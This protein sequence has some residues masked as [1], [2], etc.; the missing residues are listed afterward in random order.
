MTRSPSAVRTAFV[1]SGIGA[2]LC[3]RLVKYWKTTSLSS[4]TSTIRLWPESVISVS[5]LGSRLAQ[6]AKFTGFVLLGSPLPYCQTMWPP[7]VISMTR[8]LF[9][10]AMRMWPLGSSSAL[11]GL[12]SAPGPDVGPYDQTIDLLKRPTS[13]TRLL[14]WSTIMMLRLGSW[15]ANTGTFSSLGPEPA[16]P[17]CPYCQ[18]ILPSSFTTITRLSGQA[19][20]EST[21]DDPFGT[22]VPAS[23]VR[24]SE[25]R[26]ASL[27]PMMA[28]GPG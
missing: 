28:P 15:M 24:P 21:G 17:A 4:V 14:A 1:G 26:S 11:F 13:T 25:S 16:T 19:K 10:S 7:R 5:P 20:L 23:K 22:P 27:V 8:L 3:P 18:T 6:E 2:L 9:S 12:L